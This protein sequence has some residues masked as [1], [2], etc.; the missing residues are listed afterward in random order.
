MWITTDGI[1]SEIQATKMDFLWSMSGLTL[2]Q[3]NMFACRHRHRQ[4]QTPWMSSHSC[5]SFHL[6]LKSAWRVL[7]WCI[8]VECL[9]RRV[10]MVTKNWDSHGQEGWERWWNCLLDPLSDILTPALELGQ[11][12]SQ[13]IAAAPSYQTKPVG[14][15]RASDKDAFCT[16]AR[17]FQACQTKRTPY[18]RPRTPMSEP[19]GSGWWEEGQSIFA[20]TSI[21][22]IWKADRK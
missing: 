22:N 6:S 16:R 9:C 15:D 8:V 17:R 18:G 7:A 2:R 1:Q 13:S 11:G 5:S 21:P 4:L 12:G 10:S 3:V 14:V 20:W 19:R